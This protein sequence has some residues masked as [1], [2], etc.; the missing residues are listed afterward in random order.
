MAKE[1]SQDIAW[2]RAYAPPC[3]VYPYHR[4]RAEVRAWCKRL[5]ADNTERC[6]WCTNRTPVQYVRVR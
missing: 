6:K 1:N 2:D 3:Q 5:R 4:T